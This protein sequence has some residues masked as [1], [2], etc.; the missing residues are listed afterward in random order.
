MDL[1]FYQ[2]SFG[3]HRGQNVIWIRFEKDFQHIK[4]LRIA[5]PS[6]KWSNTQKAWYLLDLPSIRKLLNLKENEIGTS[7]YH[8]ISE[9]NHQALEDFVNQLKLKAYSHNT[10]RTYATEFA[11]LLKILKNYP[12]NELSEQRLKGYFLYCVKS[13]KIKENHLHSRINA[14]KFYFEQ[15][16]HKSTMFFDIPRPKKPKLL[17]KMLTKSEIKRIFD[18]TENTKHLLMLQ[19][20]YGM[21]L[22]VSE[23]VNLKIEHINS[24]NML[25]LISGAKGKK[26]R[27]TNLPQSVLQLLR[28]YY[29]QYR[30]KEYLFEG[31][32]GGAYTTRSVQS[33]FKQAMR[34]AKINKTIGV[35]GLRHSY[36][37]HLIESGA[38]IRFLQE[39]LGH[40]SLKTTQIYTH[41]TDVSKSHIKS[42]LDS[43]YE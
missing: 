8:Q 34:R 23:I 14:V 37:T 7:F 36:A 5:F 1:Q 4:D 28:N 21:G 20:S 12:V 27:Y 13:E 9:V 19:L 30:P 38:D 26:D 6:A 29:I 31:Q 11:H 32:Y 33:V 15:V 17:P 3:N 2:F 16:L 10:I 24:E 42:P 39:L 43:F 18:H 35:H 40:N 41:I 22:R 25:V